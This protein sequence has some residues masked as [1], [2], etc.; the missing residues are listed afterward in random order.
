MSEEKEKLPFP[1]AVIVR[2]LKK[3]T[4]KILIRKEVKKALNRLLGE[5][6]ENIAKRLAKMPY[7][8]IGISEFKEAAAPYLKVGLS[9]Q[10][11]KRIIAGLKKIKEEAATLALEIESQI[12]EEEE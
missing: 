9:V 4:G 1:N 11:K 3:H 2:L 12:E 6:V 10:E 8:Y 7:A 5:I